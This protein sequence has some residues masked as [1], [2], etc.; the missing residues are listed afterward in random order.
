MENGR[1][2]KKVFQYP[3]K[4]T[5]FSKKDDTQQISPEKRLISIDGIINNL[6]IPENLFIL[7]IGTGFGYGAVYLMSWD[8]Q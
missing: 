7:D 3:I 6:E 2:I 5:Q 8:I 4:F 1:V